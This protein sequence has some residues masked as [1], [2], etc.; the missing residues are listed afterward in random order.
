MKIFS[1]ISANRTK[2]ND[3]SVLIGD[4]WFNK[5]KIF[6]KDDIEEVVEFVKKNCPEIL[7]RNTYYVRSFP[8]LFGNNNTDSKR[9][10]FVLSCLRDGEGESLFNLSSEIG[11]MTTIR[12]ATFGVIEAGKDSEKPNEKE[13]P[14]EKEEPS[15]GGKKDNKELT[16][17]LKDKFTLKELRNITKSIEGVLVKDAKK[18]K[19]PELVKLILDKKSKKEIQK[20][21]GLV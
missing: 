14:K 2:V 7:G 20:L 9:F 4:L 10:M 6:T 15:K 21:L 11:G 17:T 12:V 13:E 3:K 16:D 5:T 8:Q 1:K 19:Q 18:M